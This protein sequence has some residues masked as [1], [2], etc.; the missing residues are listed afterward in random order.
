MRRLAVAATFLL[1]ALPT[2]AATKRQFW[3]QTEHEMS[4][5]YLAP[6]GTQAFG[7]NQALNDPDKSVSADERL[8]ITGV[9]PGRYDVKLVDTKG[10][11]CMVRN[12]SV[13]G[14]GKVAFT[15][16]EPQLTDCK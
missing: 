9:A 5:V 4:G 14:P 15:I 7:P 2:L 1:A 13:K 8:D 16:E 6:T 3:N 10:R 12:V 11:T